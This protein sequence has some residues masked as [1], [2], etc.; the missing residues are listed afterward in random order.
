MWV[1]TPLGVDKFAQDVV[2]G[3]DLGFCV[4]QVFFEGECPVQCDS[5]INRVGVVGQFVAVPGD[6]QFFFS[7]LGS[8]DG[9]CIVGFL[10]GWVS[11]G[12]YC[13]RLTFLGGHF[14][15]Q[16]QCFGS[17]LVGW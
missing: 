4:F 5:K 11:G 6:A 12:C 8:S 9:S 3:V 10:M 13:N 15:G 7:R 1:C 14:R 17:Q 16:T 2:A